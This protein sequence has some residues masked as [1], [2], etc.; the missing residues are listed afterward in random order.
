M[1]FSSRG[2]WVMGYGG[3]MGYGMH[4]SAHQVSGLAE[5]WGITGY[6]FSQVWV[7]TGS[8]VLR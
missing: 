4:F 8:T 5:L 7:M 2:V 6:G 3:P 1:G